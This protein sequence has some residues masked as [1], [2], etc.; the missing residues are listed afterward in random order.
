MKYRF[1]LFCLVLVFCLLPYSA[2]AQTDV[3]EVDMQVS[4]NGEPAYTN[5]TYTVYGGEQIVVTAGAWAG[6]DRIGYYLVPDEGDRTETVD[7]YD[8]FLSFELPEYPAG[9]RVGLFIEAIASNDNGQN[10]VVTKTGWHYYELQYQEKSKVKMSMEYNGSSLSPGDVCFVSPGDI[11]SVKASAD[12]GIHSIGYYYSTNGEN[13]EIVD[14]QE[15]SIEITIP[16][17]PSYSYSILWI[18]ALSNIREDSTDA[19]I[20]TNWQK[21]ILCYR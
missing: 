16:D 6:I 7:V 4:I 21:I 3:C 2:L 10:N 14:V 20:R 1:T 8:D 15:S 5:G 12:Y 18:E 19:S 13:T 9:T 11:I 17:A